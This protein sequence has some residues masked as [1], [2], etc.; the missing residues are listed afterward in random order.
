MREPVSDDDIHDH[1][2]FQKYGTELVEKLALGS[3]DPSKKVNLS[4]KPY[5]V[6]KLTSN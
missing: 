3:G 6:P 5:R 1:L 4:K 2:I